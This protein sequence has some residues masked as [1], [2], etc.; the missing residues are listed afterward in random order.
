MAEVPASAVVGFRRWTALA[1]A[2]LCCAVVAVSGVAVYRGS[3]LSILCG[4]V[5]GSFFLLLLVT[6]VLRLLAGGPALRVT[7]L[8]IDDPLR[9][10]GFGHL[11]WQD[12]E[13]IEVSD[14]SVVIRTRSQHARDRLLPVG[15]WTRST[16]I[17]KVAR[18][19]VT[20]P[21]LLSDFAPCFEREAQTREM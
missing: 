18:L 12:V 19:F 15:P 5:V 21:E 3:V 4:A 17:F 9:L 7:S 11:A 13:S 2:V 1:A 20:D 8:G 16:T 6:N 14:A 10:F